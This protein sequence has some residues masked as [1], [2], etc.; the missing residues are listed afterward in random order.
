[1]L[2]RTLFIEACIVRGYNVLIADIDAVWL[3]DPFIDFRSPHLSGA[4]VMAPRDTPN[5]DTSVIYIYIYGGS[6]VSAYVNSYSRICN[7]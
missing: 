3:A 7:L 1:M 6:N 4:H 5:Y 2:M